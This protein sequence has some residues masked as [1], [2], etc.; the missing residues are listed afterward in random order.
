M[1][2]YKTFKQTESLR[3]QAS[4]L[5]NKRDPQIVFNEVKT[6]ALMMFP[7]FDFKRMTDVFEDVVRLF[8]GL[9]PGYR[10]CNTEYHNLEHTTDTLL[11]TVRLIHGAM[12]NEDIFSEKNV[13]LG[14]ISALFHDT[15]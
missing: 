10:K 4:E 15:G 7:E 13:E 1:T 5:F 11:A 2:E 9:Y 14:L 6:I 8:K 3:L 12:L